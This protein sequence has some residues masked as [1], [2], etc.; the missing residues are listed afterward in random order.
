[1]NPN[2]GWLLKNSHIWPWIWH[3][4]ECFQVRPND[5]DIELQEMMNELQ[6]YGK[7]PEP[8]SKDQILVNEAY[9]IEHNDKNWYRYD[10]NSNLKTLKLCSND[11]P[12]CPGW[13]YW[14]PLVLSCFMCS[15]VTMA[16]LKL[17]HWT[18]W[19]CFHQNFEL[20]QNKPLKRKST[21]SP[22]RL[23]FIGGIEG[24]FLLLC[25]H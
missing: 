6:K 14:M 19:R 7:S 8:V 24:I 2:F 12:L 4:I 16:T 5:T 18:P 23:S 1:M 22:W 20:C 17:S 10:R 9:A 21:V 25:R 13:F 3:W 15:C 11:V